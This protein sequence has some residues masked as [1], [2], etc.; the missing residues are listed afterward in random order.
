MTH[1]ADGGQ[2]MKVVNGHRVI[3]PI[4]P[5]QSVAA[6]TPEA[7]LIRFL[8]RVGIVVPTDTPGRIVDMYQEFFADPDIAPFDFTTFPNEEGF[9][10]LVIVKDIKFF[11]F[12]EH[13]LIPF[14]GK[15]HVGYLPHTHICGLSKIPRVVDWYAHRPQLQERL[16]AQIADYI[17]KQ[18]R[19]K[20]VIVVIEAKHLCVAMRGIQK[21]DAITIT[22]ALR[23]VFLAQPNARDEFFSLLRLKHG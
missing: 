8:D 12:C 4:K 23:G 22:S 1:T 21:P 6:P 20:G 17:R 5:E 19:P 2:D 13:H 9:G 15:V 10:D 7:L 3:R 14:F 16:T 18:L 11:S